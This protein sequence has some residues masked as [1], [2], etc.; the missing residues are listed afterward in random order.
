MNRRRL[1]SAFGL[2]MA[3]CSDSSGGMAAGVDGGISS[4]LCLAGTTMSPPEL[5]QRDVR[6]NERDLT[7]PPLGAGFSTLDGRLVPECVTGTIATETTQKIDFTFQ[8]VQLDEVRLRELGLEAKLGL[9]IF[10][11]KVDSSFALTLNRALSVNDLTIIARVRVTRSVER[12]T[13]AYRLTDAADA[14]RLNRSL[15]FLE[16]C[17]DRFV[18]ERELGGD[19]LVVIKVKTR[20]EEEKEKIDAELKASYGAFGS[21][22]VSFGQLI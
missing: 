14:L 5:F 4:P 15:E 22:E 10:G 12:F 21:A 11:V 2:L 6:F 8:R 17:G 7:S 18:A 13:S 16:Q 3:A 1:A 20:S 9:S 19:L